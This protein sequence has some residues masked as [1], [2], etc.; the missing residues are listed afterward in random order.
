MIDLIA[1]HIDYAEHWKLLEEYAREI[2]E[3]I[4]VQYWKAWIEIYDVNDKDGDGIID[5]DEKYYSWI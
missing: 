3:R 5:E 2:G 1:D 4:G